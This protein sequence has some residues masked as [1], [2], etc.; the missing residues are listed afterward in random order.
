MHFYFCDSRL[1]AIFVWKRG[2]GLEKV[3]IYLTSLINDPYVI[4]NLSKTISISAPTSW[5]VKFE[6][7]KLC[8]MEARNYELVVPSQCSG[9]YKY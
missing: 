6:I 4:K 9:Q 8:Q 7:D 3:Q 1:K 2:E 5:F